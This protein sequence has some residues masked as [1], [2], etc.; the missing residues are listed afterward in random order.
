MFSF[1]HKEHH[2]TRPQPSK[3]TPVRVFRNEQWQLCYCQFIESITV[4]HTRHDYQIIISRFFKQV[5]KT[6]DKVSRADIEAFLHAPA[7]TGRNV[8]QPLSAYTQSCYYGT[9]CSWF[10]WCSEYQVEF[11]GKMC[12]ILRGE[13]PTVGVKRIRL[14]EVERDM[15]EEE[16][17]NFFAAIDRTTLIGKRDYAIFFA[18]L[19]TGR[20]KSEILN[21]CWCDLEQTIFMDSG[22]PRTGWIYHWKGKGKLNRDTA[23]WPDSCMNAL[24]EYLEALGSWEHMQP[25]TPLFGGIAG[26]G[27]KDTPMWGDSLDRRF[28][29]YARLAAIPDNI[30]C[31]SLRHENAWQRY[32]EGG[33]DILAVRDALRHADVKTTEHYL[34]R[35]QQKLQSDPIG[36]KIATKFSYL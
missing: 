2:M 26:R 31:H 13:K 4:P 22:R 28:R 32:C 33:K 5:D 3:S 19:I 12:P 25:E 10:N 23:E 27:T 6:P 24:K 15:S 11:R 29:K 21:L 9:L 7:A 8:G 36:A 17:R 30:V 18:L 16:V 1:S 35:R 34:R 14:P 20:R